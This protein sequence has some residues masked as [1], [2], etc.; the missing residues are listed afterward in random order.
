MF[1]GRLSASGSGGNCLLQPEVL[2]STFL[3]WRYPVCIDRVMAA[4]LSQEQS[5]NVK[6]WHEFLTRISV[7]LAFMRSLTRRAASRSLDFSLRA[8]LRFF[9]LLSIIHYY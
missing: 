3:H 6:V 8:I 7:L 1:R 9:S 4:V 2:E 5:S